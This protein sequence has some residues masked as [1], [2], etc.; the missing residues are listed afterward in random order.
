MIVDCKEAGKVAAVI[1]AVGTQEVMYSCHLGGVRAIYSSHLIRVR[2]IY[3]SHLIRVRV[4]YSNI[5]STVRV[6]YS[7]HLDELVFEFVQQNHP[8]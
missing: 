2:A 8:V 5:F 7:S 3:S 6:L 4:I 1:S